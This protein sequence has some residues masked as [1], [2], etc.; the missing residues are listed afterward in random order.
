MKTSQRSVAIAAEYSV[1]HRT[2][3]RKA[4]EAKQQPAKVNRKMTQAFR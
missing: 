2:V 3:D 4:D 1:Q